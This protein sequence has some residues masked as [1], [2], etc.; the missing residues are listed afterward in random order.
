MI[1]LCEHGVAVYCNTRDAPFVREAQRLDELAEAIEHGNA[2]VA[3]VSDKYFVVA[4]RARNVGGIRESVIAHVT[5]EL[6]LGSKNGDAA[7]LI[8]GDGDVVAF[9]SEAQPTW[10]VQLTVTAAGRAEAKTQSAIAAA[11][12]ADAVAG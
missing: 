5:D 11:E 3:V 12:H 1:R 6:A 7:V 2:S 9:P 8:I 4:D 10:V